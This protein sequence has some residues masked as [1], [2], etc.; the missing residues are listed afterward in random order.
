MTILWP[1]LHKHI[2]YA[3]RL[4]TRTRASLPLVTATPLAR[5]NRKRSQVN[6]RAF[7]LPMTISCRGSRSLPS[8]L[9]MNRARP[10]HFRQRRKASALCEMGLNRVELLTPSLSEKCSNRLSYRPGTKKDRG[11]AVEGFVG[12]SCL[13]SLPSEGS[14]ENRSAS[15]RRS[16]TKAVR[17]SRRKEVIQPHLPVRLPCYDFTLLTKRTFG[18]ALRCRLD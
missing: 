12:H 13:K 1:A 11:R 3:A 4:S 16:G 9:S 17:L 5:S 18:V 14:G 8:C 6:A 2:L 10:S 7:R 15:I